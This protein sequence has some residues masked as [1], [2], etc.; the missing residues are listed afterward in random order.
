MAKKVKRDREKV[1][2]KADI[3]VENIF[4]AVEAYQ[5]PENEFLMR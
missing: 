1:L 4:K 3:K 5:A 2:S